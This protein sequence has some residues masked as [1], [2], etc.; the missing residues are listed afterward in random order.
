M[1]YKSLIIVTEHDMMS[2]PNFVLWRT[3]FFE[4]AKG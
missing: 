2:G 3:E 1:A 4:V